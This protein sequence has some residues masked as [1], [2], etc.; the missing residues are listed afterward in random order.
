MNEPL[1]NSSNIIIYQT[2]DGLTRINVKVEDETVW[3]F[4]QQQMAEL[5]QCSRTNVVEHIK[6]IYEEGELIEEG[7]RKNSFWFAKRARLKREFEIYRE[8]E[9]RQLESDFDRAVKQLRNK[10]D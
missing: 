6:N 3:F 10:K 7:T 2:E 8:R 9:M 1:N 4:S 5:F